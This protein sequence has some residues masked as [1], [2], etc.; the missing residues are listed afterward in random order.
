MMDNFNADQGM[1]GFG[2]SLMNFSNMQA[3]QRAA[4]SSAQAARAQ[5]QIKKKKKKQTDST[6]RQEQML[7][8][9]HEH[10]Q[11]HREREAQARE[12]KENRE[13]FEKQH[14][15]VFRKFVAFTEG[16]VGYIETQETC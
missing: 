7:A 10:A 12:E 13:Q 4:T 1:A 8:K 11:H 6:L 16:Y 14:L 2:N 5:E 3:N 9:E 15:A